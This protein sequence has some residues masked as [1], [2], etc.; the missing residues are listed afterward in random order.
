MG[1]GKDIWNKKFSGYLHSSHRDRCLS[2]QVI[3]EGHYNR[4]NQEM[5]CESL[6]GWGGRGAKAG[7]PS[8]NPQS[9]KASCI[10]E[11]TSDSKRGSGTVESPI[12]ASVYSS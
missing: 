10:L 12:L 9:P 3:R 6:G 8:V 7:E 4:A 1:E 5:V 11:G 2:R